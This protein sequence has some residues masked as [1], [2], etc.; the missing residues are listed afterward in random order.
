MVF[1]SLEGGKLYAAQN[2]IDGRAVHMQVVALMRSILR[3]VPGGYL[4]RHQDGELKYLAVF[5]RPEVITQRIFEAY[6]IPQGLL[7]RLF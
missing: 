2:R 6:L 7:L 3:Q 4:V 5:E 1:A